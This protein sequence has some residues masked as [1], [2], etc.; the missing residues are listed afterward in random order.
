MVSGLA[1]GVPAAHTG[2]PVAR[3]PRA[4]PFLRDVGFKRDPDGRHRSIGQELDLILGIKEWKLV[5]FKLSGAIFR[6]GAAFARDA[7][8]LSYYTSLRVRLNF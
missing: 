5:E 7:G 6:P 1:E 4:A 8:K 2:T 3:Q